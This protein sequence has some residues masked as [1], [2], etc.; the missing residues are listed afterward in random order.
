MW[1]SHKRERVRESLRR[2]HSSGIISK[3]RNVLHHRKYQISSPN[4]LWHIDGYH[5]LICWCY[6]IHGGIDGFSQLITFLEVAP[7]NKSDTVLAAFLKAV[8]EF[9]LPSRVRMDRGSEN[10]KVASFMIGHPQ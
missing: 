2:V 6:V 9:G 3:C 7:N 4:E 8:D 1:N 5:K 10:V